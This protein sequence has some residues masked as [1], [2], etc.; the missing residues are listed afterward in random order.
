MLEMVNKSCSAKLLDDVSSQETSQMEQGCKT[1][2]NK[3]V[4]ELDIK[5]MDLVQEIPSIT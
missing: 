5:V 4:Y 1:F 3:T 2:A